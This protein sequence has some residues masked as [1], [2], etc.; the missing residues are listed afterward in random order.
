MYVKF[1]YSFIMTG[2][3]FIYIAFAASLISFITYLLASGKFTSLKMIGR[4]SYLITVLGIIA[5]SV[6]QMV[7]ILSKNYQFTYVWQYTSNEL[8]FWYRFAAF[9]SGQEGSFLLWAL[10][11]AVAGTLSMPFAIKK[12]YEPQAFFVFALVLSF[13]LMLLIL[14]SPFTYVWETFASEGVKA[15]FT[16]P[17]GRGLNPVLQ[18]Y[19][20]TIHP[21]ILFCGFA[22]MTVPYAFAIAGLMKREYQAW[23][24]A[25]LPLNLIAAG[26]LGLGIML[27]GL[28]AY[29]TLGWGGFWGWDPVEN[30]SLL[31]WLVSA[32]LVHTLLVQKRTGGLV[33]TNFMLAISGFLLVLYSTFLTRS[34]V[35]GDTSVH[36]FVDPGRTV[37]LL[38]VIFI[39]LFALLGIGLIIYRIKDM[40]LTKLDFGVFSREFALTMGSLF[41]LAIALVVFLGT[42]MPLFTELLNMP[43][44]SVEVSFYDKWN[45]P[46]AIVMMIV[47]A[48]SMFLSWKSKSTIRFQKKLIISLIVAVLATFIIM[49]LK[50]VNW[51]YGLLIFS[52]IFAIVV[53]FEQIYSRFTRKKFRSGAFVAHIGAGFLLLGAVGNGP[54]SIT[55]HISLEFGEQKNTLGY[56]F[57]YVSREQVETDLKDREKY[58]LHV[59]VKNSDGVNIIKPIIYW[60]DFNQREAPFLEPGIRAGVFD[61]LYI[62]P[63]SIERDSRMPKVRLNK[64]IPVPIPI[65]DRKTIELLKFDMTKAAALDTSAIFMFDMLVQITENGKSNIDT[66]SALFDMSSMMCSP[67][68]K[69]LSGTDIEAGFVRFMPDRESLGNST[70]IVAFK[71]VGDDSQQEEVEIFTFDASVK[72]FIMLVWL[73]AA[74]IFIG[75]IWSSTKYLGN[76]K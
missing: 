37:Y 10:L 11:I 20:I 5:I 72:P 16:P 65:D 4:T 44:S 66:L 49:L 13:I 69:Q 7:N 28:W 18:N 34:G 59:E 9:Y 74:L 40:N 45:M 50:P 24:G 55:E 6:Y 3:I 75:F 54:Y 21:P 2:N 39:L 22:A 51:V 33:K 17:N 15:G 14:K 47:N 35:L 68:W 57:K 67:L 23:L 32:A 27:G 61:D 64:G 48:V 41:L 60:S 38:L 29:E 43:K 12:G 31:P 73:G 26:V 42:S 8:S 36:S 46:I 71:N 56:S 25:A 76:K 58:K 52:S 1:I 70:A 53:N 63:K 62:S 19:W 30:A